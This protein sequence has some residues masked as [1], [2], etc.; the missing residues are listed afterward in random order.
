M[1]LFTF[2]FGNSNITFVTHKKLNTMKRFKNKLL[3]IAVIHTLIL[4]FALSEKNTNVNLEKLG[5][6]RKQSD[7]RVSYT[8]FPLGNGLRSNA[9][10]FCQYRLC[11]TAFFSQFRD[12]IAKF[13]KMIHPFTSSL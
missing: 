8:T 6:Q 13:I 10:M 1:R 2:F 3:F 11:P 5:N 4:L 9:Q 12:N 7:V